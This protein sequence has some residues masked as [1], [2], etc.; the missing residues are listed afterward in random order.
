[1]GYNQLRP[2]SSNSPA[3]RCY[4][5]PKIHK[6]NMPMHPI[7]SACG[8]AAYNTAKFITKIIQKY[9]GKTS[10]FV[11]DSTDFIKKIKYLS[12]NPEE[13]TLV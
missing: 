11:K 9:C 7:V 12:I 4:G 2:H 1:M 8:T 3:A 5:L 13:E 10:T 6:D